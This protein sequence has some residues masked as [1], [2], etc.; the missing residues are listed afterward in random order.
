MIMRMRVWS[1]RDRVRIRV[2]SERQTDIEKETEREVQLGAINDVFGLI[3]TPLSV[4][5]RD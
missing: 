5:K 2:L 1:E 4:R 3:W